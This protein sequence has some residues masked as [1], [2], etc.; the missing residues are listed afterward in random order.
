MTP[1]HLQ[2]RC[3]GVVQGV[4]FRPAVHRLASALGLRGAIVNEQGE[5]LLDLWGARP[6]L[7]QF[8][9]QLSG[10]LPPQ[11]QLEPLQPQ[12]L[13][14]S[15]DGPPDLRIG[16][17]GAASLGAGWVAP[18]L[19]PDLAPCPACLAELRDPA[20]RRHGYPFISCSSCGPRYSIATAEPYCRANT[21]LAGFELCPDC[22]HEFDDPAD[23]RFHAET[24]GCPMCGP[25]LRWLALS[26]PASAEGDPLQRAV[27]LLRAGGIVAV[28]GVGGFQLLVDATNATAVARL[29]RRKRRPAKPL[30]LLVAALAP[31]ETWLE[32]SAA[33]R[34]AL[35]APQ[36]PIVLLR[37][38]QPP[39]RSPLGEGLAPGSLELGV[40]LPASPLH[41]LLADACGRPLVATSGNRSGEPI[42]HDVDDALRRLGDAAAPIADGVLLHNRAIARPLDDSVLRCIDEKPVLLRRA[43]GYAPTPLKLAA[44]ATAAGVVLA[45][46]SDLKA[47][48]ALALGARVWVAPQLGDLANSRSHDQWQVGLSELLTRHGEQLETICSDQHPGYRSVQWAR[49]RCRAQPRWRHVAVQHHHAHALAVLAEHGREPPALVLAFD[50]LG[51][52][53]GAVPLWGGEGFQLAANG[54]CLRRVTLR[55]FPLIGA[56]RAAVEPRRVALGLL[57]SAGAWALQHPGAAA[58]LLAFTEAERQGLLQA[59]AADCQSPRTSSA[60]RLF[61]AVASLLDL[62]QQLSYEGQGGLVLQGAAEV[63]LAAGYDAAANAYPLPLVAAPASQGLPQWWDWQPLLQALLADRVAGVEAQLCALRFHQ[64]LT[65]AAVSWVAHEAAAGA[66]GPVVLCGGCFQ[67]RVLLDGSIAALRSAGLEP[68]WAEQ[69]PS[70]DGGL[71]LGQLLAVRLAPRIWV[72]SAAGA[73]RASATL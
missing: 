60:G 33:E 69:V 44:A 54:H 25:R 19:V 46:G 2:L 55:P 37:R 72:S 58:S 6:D 23:R 14:S 68:L 49:E 12:W 40:M 8:L 18:A 70:A 4:G 39:G 59:L 20:N 43:R 21:T 3:R 53:A 29:R 48:P 1:S 41:V 16:S 66:L 36:A 50:G 27:A 51:Y 34:T 57:A 11:A 17:T 45:L 63:A 73:D 56:E 67:N 32:I 30:A 62:V 9:L 15:R 61:D 7:D 24:T 10:V 22:Q 64:A 31:L 38:R 71:A 26:E 13:P 42:C 65:S 47:A 28:Q 5:V 52:G 35:M